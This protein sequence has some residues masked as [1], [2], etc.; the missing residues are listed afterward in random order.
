[1]QE[2]GT[3]WSIFRN[4]EYLTANDKSSMWILDRKK[5][6]EEQTSSSI[7]ITS[8]QHRLSFSGCHRR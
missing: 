3:A 4:L 2:L 6:L 1:M 5:L 7:A 8:R